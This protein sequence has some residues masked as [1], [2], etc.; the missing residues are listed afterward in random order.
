MS[1]AGRTEDAARAVH[2]RDYA[3]MGSAW[4]EDHG[5][6]QWHRELAE[7]ALAAADRWDREH[8][9]VRTD[10]RTPDDA[11]IGYRVRIAGAEYLLH[12]SDVDI[13]RPAPVGAQGEAQ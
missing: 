12:P 6:A 1:D 9:I 11:I 13:V 5:P 10:K 7:R 3:P 8:G 2:R 4:L